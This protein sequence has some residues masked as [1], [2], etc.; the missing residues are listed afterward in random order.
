MAAKKSEGKSSAKDQV[1]VR[2]PPPTLEAIEELRRKIS[3]P[4]F[5]ANRAD[6]IR[7]ALEKGIEVL[8]KEPD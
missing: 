5:E 2:L 3:R 6:A 4:G 1:T 8:R 7:V